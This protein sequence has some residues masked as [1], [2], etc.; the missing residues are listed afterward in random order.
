MTILPVGDYRPDVP[1]YLGTH[2]TVATN[3]YPRPDGSD[4]PMKAFT[5]LSNSL[6]LQPT[7]GKMMRAANGAWFLY[8]G[9]AFTNFIYRKA[10]TTFENYQTTATPGYPTVMGP[11]RFDQFGNRAMAVNPVTGLWWQTIGDVTAFTE[12][13]GAPKAKFLATVEPGFLVLLNIND[14]T[15]RPAGVR[16]SAINDATDFPVVGTS[17]A[18]SKQSDDQDLPIGGNG[19]GILA[20]IGGAAA[21]VFTERAIYRMEY[22]GAPTIFAFRE[23]T[24]SQGNIAQSGLI[25]VNGAAYFISEDG[26]QRFDGQSVT[27]IGLGRVSQTFLDSVDRENMHRVCVAHDPARKII[28]WAYPSTTATSGNPNRW[29]IYSYA[30]DKWR[31]SDDPEV[32]CICMFTATSDRIPMDNLDTFYP[33]GPDSLTTISLDSLTLSGGAPLLGGFDTS[34][35]YGTW[36]GDNLAALVETGETDDKGR[37][38]FVT[39]I[40]P[41]TDAAAPTAALGYR[42][43]FNTAVAYTSLTSQEVTGICAQRTNTRYARARIY[44]PAAASWSYLQGADVIVRPAGKR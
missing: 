37:R 27:P 29:L 20:A 21:A 22:V 23:I 14:G 32:E 7:T 42:E 39:G 24:R 4:G 43:A 15:E 13:A 31:Y 9:L 8:V 26:F 41:L 34:R 18:A 38:V 28:V 3:V 19:T 10:P 1:A 5:A 16:W 30:T 40:R 2:A 25:A 33:G 44:I 6:P 11:W 17:D 12:V 36:T 35:V